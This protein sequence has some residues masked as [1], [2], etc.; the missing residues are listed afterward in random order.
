MTGHDDEA[1]DRFAE[2]VHAEGRGRAAWSAPYD[3]LLAYMDRMQEVAA[4]ATPGELGAKVHPAE[5][6]FLSHVLQARVTTDNARAADDN[7]RATRLLVW[8]TGGLLIANAVLAV[9]AIVG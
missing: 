2:R 9:A 5:Y 4:T 7:A 3:D 6:E 1:A 8:V